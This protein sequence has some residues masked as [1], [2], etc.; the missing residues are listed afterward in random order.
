MIGKKLVG[1]SLCGQTISKITQA[2][3][4]DNSQKKY[5]DADPI[6]LTQYRSEFLE[7]DGFTRKQ[8]LY[9]FIKSPNDEIIA[10]LRNGDQEGQYQESITF[11]AS[12][13]DNSMFENRFIE[14]TANGRIIVESLVICSDINPNQVE[15][16]AMLETN[17]NNESYLCINGKKNITS[18]NSKIR[19][20][21]APQ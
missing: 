15:V 7:R 18:R 11:I 13:P 20:Y 1:E 14:R 5:Q 4:L 2:T 16:T 12:D 8:I 17:N 6:N 9:Q 19:P 3:A 21:K 10:V